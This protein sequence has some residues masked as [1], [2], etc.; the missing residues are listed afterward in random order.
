MF[1]TILGTVFVVWQKFNR[2]KFVKKKHRSVVVGVSCVIQGRVVASYKSNTCT[3]QTLDSAYE[4]K[5]VSCVFVRM[6]EVTHHG[7]LFSEFS[8]N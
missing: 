5:Y 2:K 8:R 6:T 1:T 7:H 3:E 4:R